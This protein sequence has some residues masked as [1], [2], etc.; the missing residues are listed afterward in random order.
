MAEDSYIAVIVFDDPYKGHEAR[1]AALR[2]AGESHMQL[3]ETAVA[4]KYGD[5]KVQIFQDQD[6]TAQRKNEGHWLGIAA[7]CLT[8]VQPLILAGTAAGA[9]FGRL[10]DHSITKPFIKEVDAMLKPGTSALFVQGPGAGDGTRLAALQERLH[11]YGGRLL[12]TTLP[13]DITQA[14]QQAVT[15]TD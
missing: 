14:L 15:V 3:D 7:A 9:L 2:L 8:G 13:P 11:P 12:R 1:A 5:G 6:V 4:I 10:T